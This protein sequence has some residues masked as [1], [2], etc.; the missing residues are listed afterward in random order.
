M[1]L[2]VGEEIG[3]RCLE[4]IWIHVK[5]RVTFND[6]H[7]I[8]A[9]RSCKQRPKRHPAAIFVA[10]RHLVLARQDEKTCDEAG[11]A[12][13]R[14]L[15][16]LQRASSNGRIRRRRRNLRLDAQ[17]CQRRTQFV[18]GSGRELGLATSRCAKA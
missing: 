9:F 4:A 11:S 7:P 3:S 15:D 8:I 18:R 1:R 12:I 17:A 2:R 16:L 5:Q 10:N 14:G 6:R 13:D